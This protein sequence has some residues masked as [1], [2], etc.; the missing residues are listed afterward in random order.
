MF[1][2]S[3]QVYEMTKSR[4]GTQP[5]TGCGVKYFYPINFVPYRFVNLGPS[6]ASRNMT[7]IFVRPMPGSNLRRNSAVD[8][9]LPF[10][11]IKRTLSWSD[12][13]FMT[14]QTQ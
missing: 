7:T 10:V 12:Y 13:L 3:R 4:S 8:K 11:I 14:I 9:G 1:M 2:L 6:L 5:D